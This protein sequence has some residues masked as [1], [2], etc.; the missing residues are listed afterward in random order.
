MDA[1]SAVFN[2][3]LDILILLLPQQVIWTLQLTKSKKIG[4]SFIFGVGILCVPSLAS[5]PNFLFLLILQ[6][7]EPSFALVVAFMVF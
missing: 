5:I 4:I 7:A 2:L 6:D 1:P 3:V